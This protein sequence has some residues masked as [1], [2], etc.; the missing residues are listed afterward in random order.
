MD[1]DSSID[2]ETSDEHISSGEEEEK[3]VVGKKGNKNGKNGGAE[4][5][6]GQVMFRSNKQIQ[7]KW[8]ERRCSISQIQI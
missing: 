4:H 2:S 8:W 7:N 3:I 1:C 6:C 5:A